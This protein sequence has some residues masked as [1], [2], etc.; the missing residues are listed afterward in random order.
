MQLDVLTRD[1]QGKLLSYLNSYERAIDQQRALISDRDK[2]L[3]VDPT[4]YEAKMRATTDKCQT[5]VERVLIRCSAEARRLLESYFA[6]SK[7]KEKL[8]SAAIQILNQWLEEHFH[9]P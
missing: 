4:M 7:K 5:V 1:Y 3:P 8:P 9:D 6:R 2:L